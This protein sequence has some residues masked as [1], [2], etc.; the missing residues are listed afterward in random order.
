VLLGAGAW[1]RGPACLPLHDACMHVPVVCVGP[2]ES[3]PACVQHSH[4]VWILLHCA[5]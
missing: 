1:C 2:F 3:S 5:S 4:H